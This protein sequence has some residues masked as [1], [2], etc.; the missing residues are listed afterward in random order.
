MLIR[1]SRGPTKLYDYISGDQLLR[2]QSVGRQFYASS[3]EQLYQK[4]SVSEFDAINK[5]HISKTL[6]SNP[7]ID[8]GLLESS[9][10]WPSNID[11]QRIPCAQK[12]PWNHVKPSNHI[13]GQP[14]PLD[15][16]LP[17][18]PPRTPWTMPDNIPS[19]QTKQLDSVLENNSHRKLARQLTLNPTY[20]PR[21][22]R[23][24][25]Q[26]PQSDVHAMNM[27]P[28]LPNGSNLDSKHQAAGF[29]YPPPNYHTQKGTPSNHMMLSRNASAPEPKHHHQQPYKISLYG[30][31]STHGREFETYSKN[32]SQG[33]SNQPLHA[34]GQYKVHQQHHLENHL[35]APR[36]CASQANQQ[37]EIMSKQMIHP[38]M[39]KTMSDSF[40]WSS[41]L[42]E[43]GNAQGGDSVQQKLVNT[44]VGADQYHSSEGV[45]S[46]RI[47]STS[48]HNT[49]SAVS[50]LIGVSSVPG[51][52]ETNDRVI[53]EVK[54]NLGPI[55]SKPLNERT[56]EV[57]E[58]ERIRIYNHLTALFPKDQ[59]MCVQA[60]N[61]MPEE[62]NP[63]QIC[64]YLLFLKNNQQH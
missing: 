59:A 42:V 11:H 49:S 31:Q 54:R 55:G 17:P 43:G 10:L 46:Q 7:R 20:D 12:Q 13:L 62:R 2:T 29:P 41:N 25:Q 48:L 19:D 32:S 39:H 6:S 24:Y 30:T 58:S 36:H 28:P 61:A 18:P 8:C 56:Q 1:F 47:P 52:W 27:P 51:V 15:T 22:P 45:I 3:Q 21:I 60:M 63:E 5:Q 40:V 37:S 33:A 34:H 57:L 16:S 4:N 50:P 14:L 44:G 35:I 9:S 64:K 38:P 23:S 53:H 26:L